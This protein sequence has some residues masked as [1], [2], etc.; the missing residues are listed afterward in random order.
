[1]NTVL[2][3]D[4]DAYGTATDFFAG[5]VV[6]TGHVFAGHGTLVA[7]FVSPRITGP[8]KSGKL[9]TNQYGVL[10]ADKSWTDYAL[11]IGFY[12]LVHAA[13][14]WSYDNTELGGRFRKFCQEWRTGSLFN[15]ILCALTVF[16][17]GVVAILAVGLA[18]MHLGI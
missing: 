10:M 5:V 17:F 9:Q 4:S 18:C 15:L 14:N 11:L 16:T 13:A 6:H 12:G 8:S 3:I 1:M 2:F 7:S